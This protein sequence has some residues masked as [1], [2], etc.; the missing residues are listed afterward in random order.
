MN[1]IVRNISI[2][3]GFN[4]ALPISNQ[5]KIIRQAGFSHVSIGCDYEHSGILDKT[6][7]HDLKN[8]IEKY[9][10][11]VDTVHGYDLDKDDAIEINEKIARATSILGSKVIVVHCSSFM[12]DESELEYKRI[13]VKS[14]LNKLIQI[15][16][17]YKIQFA[18][19]NVVPGIPT[20]FC[21]EMI[22][23][24]DCDE[25]GFC[26]D[27]SHDQI[28]GPRPL[29]LL[30]RQKN[31]LLALHISDRIKEFVDHV[32]PGEGF[33]DFNNICE[34]IKISGYHRPLMMEVETT[35]SKFKDSEEFLKMTYE[36][37]SILYDKIF[38]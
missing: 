14:I 7:L 11:Q 24:A 30:E 29:H 2:T 18:F 25:I 23:Y 28:D 26:Y 17:K 4:Y 9:Q 3:T 12:F 16:M 38:I 1:P 13:K 35:H 20:D 19:E 32:I 15:A 22:A 6:R 10:L 5:L 21:E 37:A 8:E 33:I 34:L 36:Q 27:S 31:N